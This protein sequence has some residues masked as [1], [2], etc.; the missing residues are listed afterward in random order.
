MEIDAF[1]PFLSVLIVLVMAVTL[2]RTVI[3]YVRYKAAQAPVIERVPFLASQARARVAFEGRARM[4]F[5]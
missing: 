3:L 5:Q 4:R 2:I 1:S